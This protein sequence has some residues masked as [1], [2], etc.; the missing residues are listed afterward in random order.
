MLVTPP[1]SS[2]PIR[3]DHGQRHG[4]AKS[5]KRKKAETIEDIGIDAPPSK[6]QHIE[7]DYVAPKEMIEAPQYMHAN[8]AKRL[9]TQAAIV[10][11]APAGHPGGPPHCPSQFQPQGRQSHFGSSQKAISDEATPG[12]PALL[13]L[14]FGAGIHESIQSTQ[15]PW[16][17]SNY[18]LPQQGA[19]SFH[20][21]FPSPQYGSSWSPGIPN[22]SIANYQ[23]GSSM[24]H[25]PYL[26]PPVQQQSSPWHTGSISSPTFSKHKYPVFHDRPSKPLLQGTPESPIVLEDA[27]ADSTAAPT[28]V[29][30]FAS[31][32]PSDQNPFDRPPGSYIRPREENKENTL[33]SKLDS[34]SSLVW[35]PTWQPVPGNTVLSP[36]QAAPHRTSQ[37]YPTGPSRP[38]PTIYS[39]L[40]PP[41]TTGIPSSPSVAPS[42]PPELIEGKA[43]KKKKASKAATPTDDPPLCAEQAALVDLILQGH[44]VFYTGSAGCGKS[45]VLRAFVKKLREMG[46]EVR[47]VAPTGRAALNVGGNTTWTFAGWTPDS[48][49]KPL[50]RLRDEAWFGTTVKKRLKATDVLVIDEISMVENLHFERLNAIMKSARHEGGKDRQPPFGGCQL[51]VTGDFCQLPPVKPFQHCIECG[52]Q[53][54]QKV[55]PEG[56]L[57]YECPRRCVYREEDKWAFRSKAWDECDF[58]HV[59]LKTIHRQNDQTF[60][61]MLQ[62]CR[63]GERLTDSEEHTLLNH[64]A[65]VSQATKLF[66]TRKEADDVNRNAFKKIQAPVHTYWAHD[67]FIWHKSHPQLRWKGETTEW[68][69]AWSTQPPMEKKPLKAL[70]DH[71]FSE[72]VEIKRGGLVVLLANIDLSAGLCNGSQGVVCGFE[73]YDPEMMPTRDKKQMESFMSKMS[74]KAR[75]SWEPKQGQ[76]VLRG[77]QAGLQEREIKDFIASDSAPIKMWPIVRFHNGQKR[78][79]YAEC[80]VTQLGDEEPYSILARTQIPL[81]PAWA[82]TVHKSQSLTLDRVIVDLSRAFEEGQVYVALSRATGLAG[83]KIEGGGQ[84][85]RDKIMVNA[86]VSAFLR[87]K[88]GDIYGP[89]EAEGVDEGGETK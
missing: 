80:T 75:D 38:L 89:I 3:C 29:P 44:N 15:Q 20:V 11:S 42:Q 53:L 48:F 40:P 88:F 13:S 86:E 1:P 85:L 70:A 8:A 39:A 47:I 9:A 62:K 32:L 45:T 82:M 16:T 33:E 34:Y 18:A 14:P 28:N 64:K 26:P 4:M 41:W 24:F 78:T 50:K 5:S 43:P 36:F 69:N 30:A 31:T 56:G 35:Q 66:C 54:K 25:N 81:A 67:T 12:W 76:R 83:L 65:R 7:D 51:V 84:F 72:C 19:Y 10:A 60:I 87:E 74:K 23:Q 61:R 2:S 46:K 22:G 37:P 52:F 77:E 71:R 49:K 55:A 21:P 17:P 27:T 68:Q 73:P 79:V 57:I 58:R 59:H 6:R 63:L